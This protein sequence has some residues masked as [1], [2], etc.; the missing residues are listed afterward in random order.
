MNIA[1]YAP[2]TEPFVVQDTYATGMLRVESVGPDTFRFVFY[3]DQ[4]STYGERERVIVSRLV[5]PADAARE[6]ARAALIEMGRLFL[7]SCVE[8]LKRP[9]H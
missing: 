6:A 8:C 7:R 5:M 9:T 1:E 4:V 2:V 3:V